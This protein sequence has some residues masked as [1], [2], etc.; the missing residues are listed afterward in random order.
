MNIRAVLSEHRTSEKMQEIVRYIGKSKTRYAELMK[1]FF[2]DEF[3]KKRKL[4]MYAAWTMCHVV[5]LQPQLMQDYWPQ[6]IKHLGKENLH[7]TEIRSIVRTWR[8][9][10]IPE[11]HKGTIVEM[12]FQYLGDYETDVAVKVYAM[13]VLAELILA[14]PDL[15][16]EFIGA[17]EALLENPKASLKARARMVFKRI[18]YSSP[19]L[20][21]KCKN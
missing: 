2:S 8:D 1:I 21:G 7:P 13:T 11:Q 16:N 4:P 3:G 9:Q 14:Y 5:D 19:L 6:L 15:R 17:V 18:G 20:I 12:C 10:E